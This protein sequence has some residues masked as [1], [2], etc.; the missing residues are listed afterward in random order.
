MVT[1]VVTLGDKV[2]VGTEVMVS[3]GGEVS[4]SVSSKAPLDK[5][6]SMTDTEG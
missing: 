4:S 3:S 2:V 5:L 6:T 1:G